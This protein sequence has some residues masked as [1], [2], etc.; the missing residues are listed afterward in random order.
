MSTSAREASGSRP[1]EGRGLGLPPRPIHAS[2]HDTKRN[3]SRIQPVVRDRGYHVLIDLTKPV[4]RRPAFTGRELATH[5]ADD[6]WPTLLRRAISRSLNGSPRPAASSST[7]STR[8]RFSAALSGGMPSPMVTPCCR[9][10]SPDAV[11]PSPDLVYLRGFPPV[12]GA[13]KSFLL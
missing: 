2:G 10:F 11:R 3:V 5:L 4:I 6:G 9:P 8:A 7:I 12:K 13:A 1:V